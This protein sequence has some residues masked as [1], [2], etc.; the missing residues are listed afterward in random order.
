M[1]LE[2][3]LPTERTRLAWQR[4][5]SAGVICLLAVLR[6]LAEVSVPMAAVIGV[7]TLLVAT[8]AVAVAIRRRVRGRRLSSQTAVGHSAALLAGLVSLACLAGMAYALL[9]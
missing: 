9:A 5:T 2:P 6:L 3:T 4:T 8:A 7:V 1:A